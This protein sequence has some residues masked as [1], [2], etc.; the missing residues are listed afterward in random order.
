MEYISVPLSES[1]GRYAKAI[2]FSDLTLITPHRAHLDL[3]KVLAGIQ[4]PAED[5][6]QFGVFLSELGYPYVEETHNEVYKRYLR[7]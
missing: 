2:C 7:K 5:S 6:A 3:G 4:A 1:R